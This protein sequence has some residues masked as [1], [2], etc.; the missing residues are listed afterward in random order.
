MEEELLQRI[1]QQ[2]LH[3][4]PKILVVNFIDFTIYIFLYNEI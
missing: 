2:G 1:K 3:V 4:T